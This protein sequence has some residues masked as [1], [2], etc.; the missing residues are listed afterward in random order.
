MNLMLSAPF[1]SSMPAS[2][3]SQNANESASAFC[4]AALPVVRLLDSAVGRRFLAAAR[5]ADAEVGVGDVA[6]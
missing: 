2:T 1:L 5:A 3:F 6:D 4:S